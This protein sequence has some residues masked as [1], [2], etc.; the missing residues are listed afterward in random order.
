[1][2]QNE[3][4]LPGNKGALSGNKGPLSATGDPAPSTLK[5]FLNEALV[6]G[7]TGRDN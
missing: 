5:T 4:N 1:M 7:L 3:T 6:L 2:S